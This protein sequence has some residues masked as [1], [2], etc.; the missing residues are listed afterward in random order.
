MSIWHEVLFRPLFNALIFIYELVP[1]QDIGIAIIILTIIIRLILFPSQS[2]ALVAQKKMKDLQPKLKKIQ[3]KFKNDK[4]KLAKAQ[5]ELYKQ[6]QI[7]PLS[8]C[9]PTLI[10]LPIIFAMYQVFRTGLDTSRLSELY[11]FIPKPDMIDPMFLGIFDMSQPDRFILPIIAGIAQ[12]IQTRMLMPPTKPK[13]NQK[14]GFQDIL[15]QQ[16][17]YIM[18]IMIV[19]FA[20]S[21][22]SALPLY[23]IV[24]A[25]FGILQQYLI[26]QGK[27]GV[28]KAVS[29]K[30][31]KR[32]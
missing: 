20:M 22:P 28:G 5:M 31:R 6:E 18:P 24:T 11:A 29:V 4:Q 19:I 9:L 26:N 8:G 30:V 21:L 1:G 7:N 14:P 16:M 32:K 25:L 27:I 17:V 3:D 12:F 10:Q 15:S 2:K 13:K 23:W